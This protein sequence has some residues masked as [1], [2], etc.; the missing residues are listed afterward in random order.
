MRNG[1]RIGRR[2]LRGFGNCSNMNALPSFRPRLV[3]ACSSSRP[4]LPQRTCSCMP[5]EKVEDEG[6]CSARWFCRRITRM[7]S[8]SRAALFFPEGVFQR[9]PLCIPSFSRVLPPTSFTCGGSVVP[10]SGSGMRCCPSR[11]PERMKQH[12]TSASRS[13][14]TTAGEGESPEQI[15]NL[16]QPTGL[17]PC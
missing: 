10:S 17:P 13:P 2:N 4:S 14:G 9:D 15:I 5:P 6:R 1:N 3:R 8:F 16:C 11:E 12:D 7:P